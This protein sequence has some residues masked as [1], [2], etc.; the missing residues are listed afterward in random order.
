MTWLDW[1]IIIVLIL[2]NVWT[3]R[4]FSTYSPGSAM[5]DLHSAEYL[6]LQD[7]M[8]RLSGENRQWARKYEQMEEDYRNVLAKLTQTEER[9]ERRTQAL[10]ACRELLNSKQGI[11]DSGE[12]LP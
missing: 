1:V 5:D 6:A 4:R 11:E 10:R 12:I 3:W 2:T 9:L 7:L 8:V